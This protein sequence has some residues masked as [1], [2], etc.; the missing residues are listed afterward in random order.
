MMKSVIFI[1]LVTSL[2]LGAP[3]PEPLEVG[4]GIPAVVVDGHPIKIPEQKRGLADDGGL[5]SRFSVGDH[6]I[7]AGGGAISVGGHAVG[8]AVGNDPGSSIS[9]HI[10]SSDSDPAVTP[11][12]LDARIKKRGVRFISGAPAIGIGT[13]AVGGSVLISGDS[14][15]KPVPGKHGGGVANLTTKQGGN[16]GNA[17]VPGSRAGD[18]GN[19]GIVIESSK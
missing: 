15:A 4:L 5:K 14:D 10:R 11:E 6:T 17:L 19:G 3:T 8:G 1:S 12:L 2:A 16:G 9:I 18:G 7:E 13:S